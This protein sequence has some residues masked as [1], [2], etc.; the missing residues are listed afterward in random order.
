LRV[1]CRGQAAGDQ[2]EGGKDESKYGHG[3]NVP[4]ADRPMPL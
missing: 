1:G 3:G 4:Q 2:T